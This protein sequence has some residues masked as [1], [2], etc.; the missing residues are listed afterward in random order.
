MIYLVSG[1]FVLLVGLCLTQFSYVVAKAKDLNDHPDDDRKLHNEPTPHTGGMGI[2]IAFLLGVFVIMVINGIEASEY[3]KSFLWYFLAGSFVMYLTGVYDDLFG[4]SSKPK[5]AMQTIASIVVMVGFHNEYLIHYETYTEAG[6]GFRLIIYGAILFW[7]LATTNMIN[8]IDGVDG[9]A[10][11]I[12]LTVLGAFMFIAITW[13]AP[14]LAV[15]ATPLAAAIIAFLNFN[16]PPASIFM[17][18][19]GSLLIGFSIG[20]SGVVL[21]F[22][23]PNY[24][25]SF[26]LLLVMAVPAIDTLFSI[27]RRLKMGINPFESDHFHIHHILQTYFRSPALTVLALS[28]LSGIFGLTSI[29]LANSQNDVIYLSV[30]GFFALMLIIISSVYYSK[31]ELFLEVIN[32]HRIKMDAQLQEAHFLEKNHSKTFEKKEKDESKNYANRFKN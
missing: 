22:Y 18:D 8:L 27:I 19:T 10:G 31:L 29:L 28:V 2:G 24:K 9:L 5:F 26:S 11:S 7:M 3:F 14:E 1:L 12:S 17:G 23:A 6:L 20:V 15:I 4:M 16:K 30:L 13:Q 25:F 21:A 32:E